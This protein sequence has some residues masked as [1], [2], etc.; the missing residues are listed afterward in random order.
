ME[1]CL[2]RL[3]VAAEGA[4]LRQ[5]E[6]NKAIEVRAL[7]EEIVRAVPLWSLEEPRRAAAATSHAPRRCA[8]SPRIVDAAAGKSYVGLVAAE[9]LVAGRPGARVV[10]IERDAAR[11]EAARRAAAHVVA[12]GVAVE[13]VAGDVGDATLWPPDAN[14]AVA[15]HACG[16]AA[17]A[18]IE[19]AA[20]AAAATLLLVPC[21]VG[22][23]VTAVRRAQ[24][25]ADRLGLSRAAPVRRSFVSAWVASE[26]ALRLEAL[27]Y[28]T[29]LVAFVSTSVTP[30]NTLFRARRVREPV[31][32]ADAA[33][34]LASLQAG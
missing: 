4:S 18:V 12:E 26:R 21:C 31:R 20:A 22:A 2:E 15:L 13:V 28:R 10:T 5:S 6:R 30:E 3:Y 1:A 27:G 17:D 11:V 32:M 25:A 8:T 9:L 14:V 29:E 7:L 23:A 19:S 24:A 33:A 16:A 34:R